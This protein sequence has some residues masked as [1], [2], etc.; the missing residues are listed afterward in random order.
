MAETFHSVV[1]VK[2]TIRASR[3]FPSTISL[4]PQP[5]TFAKDCRGNDVERNRSHIAGLHF[6]STALTKDHLSRHFRLLPMLFNP[7]PKAQRN[8]DSSA[9]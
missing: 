7:F 9:G 8:M 2:R 6:N 4:P 3:S 5:S 1:E